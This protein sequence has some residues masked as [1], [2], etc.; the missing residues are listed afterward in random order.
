MLFG[1]N[2]RGSSGEKLLER[3]QGHCRAGETDLGTSFGARISDDCA[4]D[5]QQKV[6]LIC[7]QP[8]F[9]LSDAWDRASPKWTKAATLCVGLLQM[10]LLEMSLV[11]QWLR[12]C[13]STAGAMSSIPSQGTKILHATWLGQKQTDQKKTKRVTPLTKSHSSTVLGWILNSQN[14]AISAS[15]YPQP[16]AGLRHF[17]SVNLKGIHPWC[18]IITTD[19]MRWHPNMKLFHCPRPQNLYCC[20]PFEPSPHF[21]LLWN[22]PSSSRPPPPTLSPQLCWKSVYQRAQE[23]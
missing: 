2:L 6:L 20:H 3:C 16:P 4:E 7:K 5:P 9:T 23:E 17:P 1:G 10:T 8:L 19:K 15:C 12:L 11:G 18:P 13:I 22:C 14:Q 21:I